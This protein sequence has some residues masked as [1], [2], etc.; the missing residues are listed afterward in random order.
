MCCSISTL[1]DIANGCTRYPKNPTYVF[2]CVVINRSYVPKPISKN[3]LWRH[4]IS[5][6]FFALQGIVPSLRLLYNVC[7]YVAP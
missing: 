6:P 4:L 2:L 5:F 7:Q 1:F 3:F